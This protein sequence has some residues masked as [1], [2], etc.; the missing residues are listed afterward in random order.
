VLHN[1]IADSYFIVTKKPEADSAGTPSV[2]VKIEKT[3]DEEKKQTRFGR[4]SKKD[5]M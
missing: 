3:V 2:V 5:N 4:K 1:V